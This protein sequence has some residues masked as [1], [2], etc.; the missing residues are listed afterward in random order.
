MTNQVKIN[1]KEICCLLLIFVSV[2]D[3]SSKW[4]KTGSMNIQ[5][6]Y[7]K[8]ILLND[9]RVLV[10]GGAN[11]I[12]WESNYLASCE[13][14]DPITE[15]WSLTDPLPIRRY[16]HTMTLLKDGRVLV[17]GGAYSQSGEP[18]TQLKSCAIYDPLTNHWIPVRN[19]NYPRSGHTATLLKDG[20]VLVVGGNVSTS[21]TSDY[22]YKSCEIY[23]PLIDQWKIVDSLKYPRTHHSA[24]LLPDGRVLI[25][26][27]HYAVS[28]PNI[29]YLKSCEVYD[30]IN[31]IWTETDSIKLPQSGNSLVM[32]ADGNIFIS[33]GYYQNKYCQLFL[34][35]LMTWSF[36]GSMSVGR[37]NHTATVLS[38]GKIL[39]VGGPNV[40][41]CEVF[42]P[43]LKTFSTTD[44]LP[45]DLFG[46]SAILLD[47]GKILV[48][49]GY[50]Y[51]P[52]INGY[53]SSCLLYDDK[54][55]SVNYQIKYHQNLT[56]F[57]NLYPNPFNS[58]TLFQYSIENFGVIQLQIFDI[59]GRKVKTLVDEE[60]ESGKY[61]IYWNGIDDNGN[62]ISSGL[63]FCT[64]KLN[65]KLI[66]T[67]KVIIVK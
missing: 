10:S 50:S 45:Y 25:I 14:Y 65:S 32:L 59:L 47:N 64:F 5:R 55:T 43:Y 2:A 4:S 18:F 42:D 35:S 66:T 3:A 8:S 61:S 31:N 46:H 23:D 26:S 6:A 56:N 52:T 39:I 34:T 17:T 41:N 27:G 16:F 13:I 30:P 58:S 24:A 48:S 1:L 7:H 9:G 36:L 37:D 54:I 53:Q 44:S 51:T 60:K 62:V 15:Q 22:F 29:T 33:G 49:G 11:Y 63:Y 20:R 21:P 38:N 12:N 67:N 40:K 28:Y 19:I 57:L